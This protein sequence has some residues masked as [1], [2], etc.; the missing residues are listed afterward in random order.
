MRRFHRVCPLV[1]RDWVDNEE[2]RNVWTA[3]NTQ[4]RDMPTSIRSWAACRQE[5]DMSW[6]TL[7]KGQGNAQDTTGLWDC[8]CRWSV[9]GVLDPA[10]CVRRAVD[11]A[12]RSVHSRFQL[13]FRG[14]AKHSG[15]VSRLRLSDHI[16]EFLPKIFYKNAAHLGRFLCANGRA[17]PDSEGDTQNMRYPSLKS[18][19]LLSC[20]HSCIRL[21]PSKS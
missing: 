21:T 6:F 3:I 5:A 19:Y 17:N 2:D 13:R 7:G 4:M 10:E 18:D 20:Y 16:S 15:P 1:M 12:D 11:T 8:L 14:D 9:G